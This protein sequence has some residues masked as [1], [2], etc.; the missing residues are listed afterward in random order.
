MAFSFIKSLLPDRPVPTRILRG[1]FRGARIVMNPRE[2]L[3]KVFGL[4]EHELNAW[5]DHALKRVTRARPVGTPRYSATFAASAGF[6]LPWNSFMR[7]IV[8]AALPTHL[9]S[10]PR[11]LNRVGA[12]PFGRGAESSNWLGRE[13]SNLH[14]RLQR[15]LSYR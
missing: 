14:T 11:H 9:R 7:C 8:V 15:P 5:L 10:E 4:Y 2:S 12:R 13:D 1:P 6:E 3:R